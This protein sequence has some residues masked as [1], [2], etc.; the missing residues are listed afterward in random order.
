MSDTFNKLYGPL[1]KVDEA[2]REIQGIITNESVDRSNEICDYASTKPYYKELMSEMSKATDGR[3]LFPLRE[4]H[5]LTS[6]GKGISI[7]F[8]DDKKQIFGVFKVEDNDAW[9]KVLE[10]C[11][12]GL[13]Q[14]G[15]YKK[16]WQ[17]GDYTRFTAKPIECSLVDVPALPD[18]VFQLVRANGSVELRKF[19]RTAERVTRMSA[20]YLEIFGNDDSAEFRAAASRRMVPDLAM[21][22]IEF[23]ISKP[24]AN[25]DK[26]LY[27]F[28]T[29]EERVKEIIGADVYDLLEKTEGAD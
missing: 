26:S 9:Q 2:K 10:G 1:I 29:E 6:A 24:R 23:Q 7:Q 13:S 14:G 20:D 22:S 25:T 5:G 3:N 18:A 27:Q 21:D 12:S 28:Y 11:Y 8:D 17:E 16:R 19:A 15:A 4:M